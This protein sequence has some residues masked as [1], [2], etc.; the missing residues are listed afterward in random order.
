MLRTIRNNL[1]HGGKHGDVDM[2]SKERNLELLSCGK[3]VLD[4]LAD[5]AGIYDDYR[6]WY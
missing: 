1:F 4:Q 2:D 5:G 6:R 3:I